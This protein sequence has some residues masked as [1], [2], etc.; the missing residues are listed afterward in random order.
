MSTLDP[1]DG[2]ID[3]GLEHMDLILLPVRAPLK[4]FRQCGTY[5]TVYNNN[6]DNVIGEDNNDAS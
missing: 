3:K 5:Q 6:P 4:H 1:F 2:D